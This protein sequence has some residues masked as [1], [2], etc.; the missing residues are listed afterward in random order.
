MSEPDM[1][2]PGGNQLLEDAAAWFARMRG[3]EADRS[4]PDFEAWLA[5][6]ALHRRAYNRAAE[7]FAMGKLLA[8][9]GSTSRQRGSI[10]RLRAPALIAAAAILLLVATVSLLALR[11]SDDQGSGEG[12][13]G[14]AMLAQLVTAPRESRTDQLPDGSLVHLA[15]GTRVVIRYQHSFRQLELESGQARFEVAHET[16]PFVVH[17]GGGQVTARGTVFDVALSPDA[18]VTVKLIKGVIDVVVPGPDSSSAA[19]RRL[20]AGE[21]VRFAALA[22]P[23]ATS[24]LP[25]VA[26][27]YDA[28]RVADLVG[29]ANRTASR[30]I[31]LGDP[32]IGEHRL[33]GRFR[34]DDA[35]LLAERIAHL[36][37]LSVDRTDPAVIV[38]EPRREKIPVTTP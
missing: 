16:R 26:R 30:P 23:P 34:I 19:P 31:R 35:D 37:G 4:R 18:H 28:I 8:E 24:A 21:I 27:E 20:N 32:A 33:S 12:I 15:G 10:V 36:F 2:S 25:G 6:G 17:A 29:A 11:A 7:I 38:L 13:V 14:D 9:D 22:D 5:R 3:P 1:K